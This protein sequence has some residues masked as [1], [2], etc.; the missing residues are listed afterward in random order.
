MSLSHF[1]RIMQILKTNQEIT[2][3][4]D[5]DHVK[6]F[7]LLPELYFRMTGTVSTDVTAGELEEF[8]EAI[9][10]FGPPLLAPQQHVT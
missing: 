4:G 8:I 1:N 7:L 3:Y 6:Q 10:D 5:Q 2:I 9:N